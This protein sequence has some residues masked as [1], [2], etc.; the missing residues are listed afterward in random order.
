MATIDDLVDVR[1]EVVIRVRY[2]LGEFVVGDVS[3]TEQ[4]IE[5]DITRRASEPWV[6]P[7][8]CKRTRTGWGAEGVLYREGAKDWS[9]VRR[10]VEAARDAAVTQLRAALGGA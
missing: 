3:V 9:L 7:R 4:G 2:E 1:A 10:Q 8:G 6:W 5:F